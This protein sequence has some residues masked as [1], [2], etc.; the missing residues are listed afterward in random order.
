MTVSFDDADSTPAEV[1]APVE[2]TPEEQQI[3]AHLLT[4]LQQY[5]GYNTFRPLQREAMTLVMKDHDSLVVLPTGGGKSLCYQ[6]PAVSRDGLAIV[7]SPLISLMKDQVD[8]LIEAGVSAGCINSMQSGREK[9]DIAARIRSRDLRLLYIAPERLVQ[10]R[11]LEFLQDIQVSFVAID[12]AH[13]ISQWGHDFRP[14]YRKLSC[15]GKCFQTHRYT[16][17]RQ[18]PRPRCA[19]TS[20]NS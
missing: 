1:T 17:I 13:C 7:V 2:L 3:A 16:V 18:R 20:L 15:C 12:E 11:T 14:E 5:W 6:V 9:A 8:T 10:D 4:A 19:T